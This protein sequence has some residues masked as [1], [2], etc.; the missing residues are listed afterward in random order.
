MQSRGIWVEFIRKSSGKDPLLQLGGAKVSALL[1]LEE[2]V[3]PLMGWRLV[4][5]ENEDVVEAELDTECT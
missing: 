5:E 4:K 2:A 3:S 1:E